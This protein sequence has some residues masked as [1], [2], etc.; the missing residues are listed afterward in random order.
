MINLSQEHITPEQ[1]TSQPQETPPATTTLAPKSVHRS[2]GEQGLLNTAGFLDLGDF[3][4]QSF[5]VF[6]RANL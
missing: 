1:P 3:F 6:A 5:V 2:A 4:V